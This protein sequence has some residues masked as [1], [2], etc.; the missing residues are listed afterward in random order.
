MQF[1]VKNFMSF[2]DEVTLDMTAVPHYKEHSYN[3]I[4]LGKNE[5]Y[6]RVT[7]IYGA[8]A[9]GKTNLLEA[10][11]VFCTLIRE[12]L[13]N[14]NPLKKCYKP[15][16]FQ[17]E[18]GN[19][20]FEVIHIVDEIEYRYGFEFNEEHIVLEW[21]YSKKLE[22]NRQA[23]VFERAGSTL[24]LGASIRRKCENYTNQIPN[25]TLALSFFNK[26]KLKVSVFNNVYNDL[27]KIMVVNTEHFENY[28]FL[29]HFL[30]DEI[31]MQ[32]ELLVAYLSDIDTGITNIHLEEDDT[33]VKFLTTHIGADGT[34]YSLNLKDE[35]A[36]TLK[37]LAV[38]IMVQLAIKENR[39]IFVDEL[40]AKLHPLLM[41][42]II[43]LFNQGKDSSAQLIYTTH[44]TTLMD[45]KFFR[46]DQIWFVE[47]DCLGCSSLTSLVEYKI[48]ND[49]SFEKDY[50]S[51]VYGGIAFMKRREEI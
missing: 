29:K 35:S 12:S 32:K 23:V 10:M 13:D 51:G 7:S 43:D 20:V 30:P 49:A 15:F 37:S 48:R 26:L 27:S 5:K 40:N 50:L 42:F 39:P 17:S 34:N 47:K 4:D 6:L 18:K 3:L 45:K 38:F 9:S 2:R 31:Q 28:T 16:H 46:R 41:K 36:G 1:T 14:E 8:N 19:V 22:T 33:S 25:D 21:L 11:D 24:S 44:D